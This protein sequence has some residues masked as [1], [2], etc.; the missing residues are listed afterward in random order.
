MLG[1]DNG[2]K[3]NDYTT[4][5]DSYALTKRS[6]YIFVASHKKEV[7]VGDGKNKYF[8]YSYKKKTRNTSF[9]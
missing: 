4:E 9:R 1:K 6:Y 2:P 7:F 8:K 5:G 3:L